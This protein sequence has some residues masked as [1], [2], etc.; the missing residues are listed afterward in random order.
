MKTPVND[1]FGNMPEAIAAIDVLR[2][3]SIKMAAK[4]SKTPP[5]S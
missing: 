2:R 5:K 4:R 1:I 3:K